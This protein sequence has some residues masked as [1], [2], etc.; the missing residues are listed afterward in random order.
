VS[1]ERP[2][3]G[4]P[5]RPAACDVVDVGALVMLDDANPCRMLRDSKEDGLTHEVAHRTISGGTCSRRDESEGFAIWMALPEPLDVVDR[6]RPAS[7]D[8]CR[9]FLLE[10]D[11][12][13][14]DAPER[15]RFGGAKRGQAAKLEREREDPLPDWHCGQDTAFDVLRGVAHP[16]RAT[17]RA[18][19]ASLACERDEEIAAASVAMTVSCRARRCSSTFQASARTAARSS[20]II[21]HPRA[22]PL[23]RRADRRRDPRRVGAARSLPGASARGSGRRGARPDRRAGSKARA[24]FLMAARKVQNYPSPATYSPSPAT[25]APSPATCSPSPATYSPSPAT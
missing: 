8:P 7:G 18:D 15:S 4:S 5:G 21:G 17:A 22:W 2:Q 3:H 19:A 14:E 12:L 1:I 16:A 20:G 10:G 11:R 13:Y 23:S 6:G 25:C 9:P 24:A